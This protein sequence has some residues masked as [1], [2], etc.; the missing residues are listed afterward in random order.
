MRADRTF[1]P[2][3]VLASSLYPVLSRAQTPDP[4]GSPGNMV[5]PPGGSSHSIAPYATDVPS[6]VDDVQPTRAGRI[7]SFMGWTFNV[8]LG[9][10]REFANDVSPLGF[11]LQFNG[12]LFDNLSLGVSGEWATY[13]DNR[14][15]QTFSV[16]GA[17]ITAK[18]YNSVQTTSARLLIHYAFLAGGSFRP[19]IGPHVGVSWSTFDLQAADSTLS[20]SQVSVNLGAETGTEMPLGRY[21]PVLLFNVRYSFSP[22]AEFRSTVTNVQS[23]GFMLGMGF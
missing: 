2:V 16:D 11:E 22:A 21:A 19:Y 17:A 10:V 15:R 7:S 14:P 8:P 23:L 12:W 4:V 6:N 3:V 5:T 9:S 1:L 13:V 20:D 18:L